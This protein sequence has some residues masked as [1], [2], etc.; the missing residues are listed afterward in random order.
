MRCVPFLNEGRRVFTGLLL[1]VWAVFLPAFVFA[2]PGGIDSNRIVS[3]VHD[4]GG[5]LISTSGAVGDAY[6]VYDALDPL[7]I[8]V[9][10]SGVGVDGL[11]PEIQVFDGVVEQIKLSEFQ[12]SSG[13]LGRVEIFLTKPMTSEVVSTENGIRVGLKANASGLA[14][15]SEADV[16]VTTRSYEESIQQS[17]VSMDDA[18]IIGSVQ[19]ETGKTTVI[20]DGLIGKVKHF[21][22]VDPARLVVDVYGVKAGFDDKS[23]G[24]NSG[25]KKM[26]VGAYPD[27]LRFVYDAADS[28][29]PAY[30]VD[31]AGNTMTVA[32]GGV[33]VSGK[34]VPDAV[35]APAPLMATSAKKSMSD[36]VSV[37]SVDFRVEGH[38]SILSIGLSSPGDIVQPLSTGNIIQF[39]IKRASI[40]Q[41]HR[42][43]IDPSVFPTS[44]R[45]ITPY[46]IRKNGGDEVRFAVE[47][48]EMQTYELRQEKDA[49]LFIVDNGHFVEGLPSG[50]QHEVVPVNVPAVSGQGLFPGNDMPENGKDGIKPD[51]NVPLQMDADTITI[52]RKKEYVG[53]KISLVFDDADI[54]NILQLIG[55]VSDLNIIVGDDVKG[56]M[57]LRLIDVPWD[58]ALDLVLEIR[59]LGKLQEGNVLRIL[60]LAKIRQMQQEQFAAA[61]AKEKL[62]DL[63]TD[64]IPVSY[65]DVEGL[66]EACKK[67]LSDR[68]KVIGDVR[69][70]KLI[71]TD[72]PSVVADIKQLVRLLDTPVRQVLIEA[73]IVEASATFSRD[74]G[75]NWGISYQHNPGSDVEGNDASIGMG[76]T[77]VGIPVSPGEVSSGIVSGLTFGQVGVDKTVLDLRL[78]ALEQSGHGRIVSTPR[79]S[80]LNGEEAEVAQGTE[81]P[82]LSVS[83]DGTKTEFKKAEL[84]LKVTPEINPDGSVILEIEAKNDS[85]GANTGLS[86]AP[87]IDT[88]RAT[89][90]VLVKDGETTVIGGIFI[91]DK[92]ESDSGVPWLMNVPILGHLFKSKSVSEERREL[93]VFITPR[94]LD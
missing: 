42:R 60:P 18:K 81:I 88:K 85:R 56:N 40:G 47:M 65:T 20:A 84:S 79:V 32:W 17:S 26:R 45:L 41:Q 23:F 80:T 69:D 63:V 46:T 68:G 64:L 74:L 11:D 48:K 30:S 58:Q 7:R 4:Q 44:V 55:E 49:L 2:E 14:G 78:A 22:L 90:K 53:Q 35:A 33:A 34:P 43:T 24:L 75:V 3:V 31:K 62:E 59:E 93:L 76:G 29:L 15:T 52:Q 12:L 19:V 73:R 67:R 5:V 89:T 71:V 25:L 54:R 61:R 10:I 70:K 86:E 66:V 8:V 51:G 82:Y 72:I 91:Q 13:Q 92:S 28:G 38:K 6:S 37:T 87:A 16:A 9:D 27:K 36:K 83:D 50:I 57:T 77:L 39:G 1:V 21:A 94:I